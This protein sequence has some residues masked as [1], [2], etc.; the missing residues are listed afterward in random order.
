LAK[1]Y[2]SRG[3]GEG[4]ITH[5][6]GRKKPWRVRAT[7]GFEYDEASGKTKQVM[8]N[9]GYFKTKVEAEKAVHDY[10]ECPYDVTNKDI[11][12]SEV[13][14]MWLED[15]SKKI[16]PSGLRTVTAAYAYCSDLRNKRMRDIRSNHLKLCLECGYVIRD[17]GKDKGKKVYA[18]ASTKSRMKSL[19]NIV[20]DYALERN[21]VTRNHAREFGVSDVVDSG[22]NKPK[23]KKAF[24]K[25]LIDTLWS[26]VGVYDNAEMVLINIYTGFRPQELAVISLENV[27][28]ING[29]IR[30][31][32]KT[33]AG[34]NRLVP[35]HPKIMPLVEQA[36]NKAN[37]LGSKFL[38]NDVNSQ[39]GINMTYDKYRKRFAKVLNHFGVSDIYT[40]HC[41]RVT[42][43]TL[44]KVYGMNEHIL[45]LI[46]GH[47]DKDIT[48]RVYTRRAI[49]SLKDEMNKIPMELDDNYS[50]EDVYDN[51]MFNLSTELS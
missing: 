50:N 25:E 4:N 41:C 47:E 19:F 1:K 34:K 18:S 21:M 12:F 33:A 22:D 9:L 20:F 24:S 39:T 6:A 43:I 15:Y 42:F 16:S 29:V 27:D 46:V 49:S 44:A 2:K 31:G 7:L 13:F 5:C 48:E 30:G 26:N 3:N 23:R 10:L 14:E 17:T 38:F 51:K 37:Q 35:I 11:T 45:K 36:V 40:P 28:L 8:V 32:L